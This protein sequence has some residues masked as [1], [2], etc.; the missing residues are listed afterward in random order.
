M[1]LVSLSPG[2]HVIALAAADKDG[3]TA[4]ASIDVDAGRKTCLPLVALGQ[5]AARVQPWLVSGTDGVYHTHALRI[6]Y[7]PRDEK[8]HM[9]TNVVLDESLIEKAKTLSGIKTTR[10][11]IDEA[12]RLLIRLHAQSQVRDLR[13][14]ILWEGDLAVLREA[15][16]STDN[17][18]SAGPASH[19]VIEPQLYSRI[20]QAADEHKIGI[21]RILSDALRR[22]L[23]ELDRR[24]ISE[25]SQ[26]YRERHAELKEQ[27]LGQYIAMHDGD[28]VDH[29]SDFGALR[30]RVRQQ[31]RQTPVMITLVEE[32]SCCSTAQPHSLMF[33]RDGVPS[34]MS[35]CTRY[36]CQ[37]GEIAV[38]C[39]H[40]DL[41]PV[42]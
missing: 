38:Q 25:E 23:W 20:E 41:M 22:Y 35:G 3:N 16:A 19:L 5:N 6:R 15:R 21:D 28:V 1:A 4:T 39:R 29:D 8:R 42:R 14:H 11:V 12:L 37:P 7:T 33:G 17:V 31:F 27:Y 10:A 26:V 24:K 13:G 2:Q 34:G 18:S 9:R 32:D 40:D 30:H 36:H